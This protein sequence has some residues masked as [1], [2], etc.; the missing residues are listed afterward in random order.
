MQVS[1]QK[2][3]GLRISCTEL[4]AQVLI[5]RNRYSARSQFNTQNA[6]RRT[7]THRPQVD[8]GALQFLRVST[9]P[10][11]RAASQNAWGSAT[12]SPILIRDQSRLSRP[13]RRAHSSQLP[14]QEPFK[15]ITTTDFGRLTNKNTGL[16]AGITAMVV[17]P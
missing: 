13:P 4:I 17:A 10:S 14:L 3:S 5:T 6:P 2:V 15:E 9:A 11:T 1:M 12:I 8:D 16:R 7:S